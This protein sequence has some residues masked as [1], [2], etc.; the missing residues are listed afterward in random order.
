MPKKV[1]D[2]IQLTKIILKQTAPSG[3][4]NELDFNWLQME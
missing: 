1:C 2:I 4:I 3:T